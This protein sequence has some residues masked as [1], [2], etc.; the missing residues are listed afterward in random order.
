MINKFTIEIEQEDKIYHII[1]KADEEAST[2]I[3][4]H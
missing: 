3:G 1:I 2:V 4:R